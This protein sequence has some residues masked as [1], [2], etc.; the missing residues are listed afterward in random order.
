M[1][2]V[3][4]L[5]QKLGKIGAVLPCNSSYQ[6]TF[7]YLC[8]PSP[9]FDHLPDPGSLV[10]SSSLRRADKMKRKGSQSYLSLRLPDP[11]GPIVRA[12]SR[13]STRPTRARATSAVSRAKPERVAVPPPDRPRSSSM[14]TTRSAGQPS[15]RALLASA[16]CRSVDS[17]LCST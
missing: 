7:P 4:P 3:T 16:Y 11:R 10:P 13:P 5:E 2:F 17:R 14:T 6:C 8:H 12:E 1:D 9:P 15:S